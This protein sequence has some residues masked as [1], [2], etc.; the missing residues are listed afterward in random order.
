[1]TETPGHL[2][3]FVL[4]PIELKPER[5]GTTD[6][7][8]PAGDGPFPAVVI[9]H[10][11]PLPPDLRPTPRDWPVYQGYGSLL[12]S[13]GLATALVDHRLYVLPQP[14]GVV[15]DYPTAAEDVTDA[16]TAV[17]TDPRVDGDRVVVWFFSGGGLLSAD[18]LRRQPGWLRG[19]ALSYPAL[20]PLPG[21]PVD[22]RFRPV[23]AVAETGP[24]PAPIVLTRVGLESEPIAA[25]VA[26]FLAAAADAGVPVEIIDVPNGH[27]SFDVLDHTDESREAVRQMAT[28]V[29]QLLN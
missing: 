19:I 9:V 22:P 13:L 23:E 29:E 16:V 11:G 20:A 8:L 12:A 15:L 10:G 28:R 17:R 25:S 5:T 24:T 7:Y 26:Q 4:S 6:L 21:W 27:H 1:M 14:D 2:K 18:W 3:P